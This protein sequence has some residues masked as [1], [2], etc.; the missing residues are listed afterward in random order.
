MQFSRKIFEAE[1]CCLVNENENDGRNF[2]VYTIWNKQTCINNKNHQE[3]VR[4]LSEEMNLIIFVLKLDLNNITVLW[5]IGCEF[6]ENRGC[7]SCF[8]CDIF[9]NCG[10]GSNAVVLKLITTVA[11]AVIT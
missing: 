1:R 10:C 3:I 11:V 8:G 5:I 4:R 2:L 7:G 9:E 6:T